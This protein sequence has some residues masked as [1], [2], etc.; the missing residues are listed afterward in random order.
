MT[1]ERHG[2]CESVFKK[3]G[4][5]N[6]NGMVCVNRPLLYLVNTV[7]NQTSGAGQVVTAK[8]FSHTKQSVRTG[9]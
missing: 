9:R 7:A 3:A 6:G 5:Q 8:E 2:M 1:G 4:E